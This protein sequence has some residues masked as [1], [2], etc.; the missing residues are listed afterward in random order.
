MPLN[1]PNGETMR[2]AAVAD[3]DTWSSREWED[4]VQ[5]DELTPLEQLVVRTRNSRYDITVLSPQTGDVLVQGGRFFPKPTPAKLSGASLGGSF[6]KMRGIYVGF[7]LELWRDGET[8]ITSP[9]ESIAN[10]RPDD[11]LH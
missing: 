1:E 7:R 10:A 3:L 2:V 9:V 4:G 5:V 8:V 11:V 6:L